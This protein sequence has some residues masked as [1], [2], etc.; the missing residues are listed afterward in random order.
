MSYPARAEGLVNRD[1]RYSLLFWLR[2]WETKTLIFLSFSIFFKWSQIGDLNMQRLSDNFRILLNGLHSTN[3]ILIE[4][5]RASWAGFISQCL[6]TRTKLWKL[7]KDLAV[8]NDMLAVYTKNFLSCFY[9]V[10][11]ILEFSQYML[12]TYFQF[13]HF[14]SVRS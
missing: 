2:V 8:S 6:I 12:N 7:V 14:R 4:V 13:L 1:I 9:N 5:W 11:A 3:S 10:F